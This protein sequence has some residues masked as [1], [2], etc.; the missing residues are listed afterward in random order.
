MVGPGM[1]PRAFS[2]GKE[3]LLMSFRIITSILIILV[4]CTASALAGVHPSYSEKLPVDTV[5]F[6]T[7][8]NYDQ[9]LPTPNDH[10]RHPLGQWPQR[11]HEL[12]SF[13]TEIASR[14]PRVRLEVH[15]ESYEGR[16]LYNVLVSSEDNIARLDEIK[17]GID[18]LADPKQ[19]TGKAQLDS[20]VEYSPAVAWLGYSIHGDELSGVD[21]AAQLIYHLAAG[22]DEATLN[23]LDNVVVIIDPIENPDG[24]ERYMTMLD[25]YGSHVPN[26]DKNALQHQG[27][28]PWG[29]TNHYLF[30]LN[31]DWI[32]LRQTETTGRVR[33]VVDWHPQ[34]VVDAHEMG[35]DATYLFSPPRQ[36]INYNIPENVMK[37]YSAFAKDQAGAF[38]RRGWPYYT[39]EWNDQWYPGYGSAWATFGGA[40]GILYEMAGVDGRF[41]RQRDNYL[42]TF[43]EAVNKQFTSSL[44]NIS[45]A[46]TNRRALLRDYHNTRKQITSRGEKSGLTFVI[47]PGHDEIKMKRF[48]ETLVHL[49]IDVER[50]TKAFVAKSC[51]DVFGES[52]QTKSFPS[53]AYLVRAAQPD[54]AL[55][56]AI[57]EFDP[58]LNLE[59]LEEERRE[60]E[61]FDDT[62]MYETST[63]SLPLAYGLEAYAINSAQ[64]AT[65]S[66]TEVVL[67]EGTLVNP[68]AH[69]GFVVDMV[70]EKTFL[71]MNRLFAEE[72]VFYG[73]KKPFT[74]EGRS[75]GPGALVLRSRGN[76]GNMPVIL[77]RLAE[78][79]GIDIVGVNTGLSSEGSLLGAPT[80]RLMKR[81]KIALFTG[82]GINYG[83]F[84]QLWY[85]ID[86]ELEIP[87]S[88]LDIANFNRMDLSP[89]N[90]LV[91]P[92]SWGPLSSRVDKQGGKK[93]KQWVEGG[94]TLIC[95]NE[96]AAWAADT[97]RGFCSVRLKRQVL[98]K[99]PKYLTGL[100]RERAAESPVV[101]TMAI[102]H[103][104][105]VSAVK[106]EDDDKPAKV[107]KKTAKENDKWQRK[108]FPRGV[109]FLAH[110][111][112]DHWMNIG[113]GDRIPVS[114]YGGYCFMADKPVATFARLAD[115]DQLRLSG[116]LWP[117]ARERWANGVYGAREKIGKGQIIMFA[118]DPNFRAYNYGTRTLF[119]N[120]LLYGPGMGS[121]ANEPYE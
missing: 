81:P 102:W 22:N 33:T 28:Y 26:Y 25:T 107:D 115:T 86:R 7:G 97:A 39:G 96:S 45:T 100:Q 32:L 118:Q 63:W 4:V 62:R 19:V 23:I 114:Y 10:L 74:I 31:R 35:P 42:L 68:D 121:S 112:T 75:F 41:V 93:L 76:P 80:F 117:E 47:V 78:D 101:D 17:R 104:E 44:A 8:G 89:Y 103:P 21:A 37:W 48:V 95:T 83:S 82:N 43:H 110:L 69:Y 79:I 54:G 98:D 27:V 72:L 30:D 9:S 29:R 36:P 67:S 24:R 88:L 34:L 90:V 12:V 58:H 2:H 116:L 71:L 52:S 94:G 77:G 99:L 64:V 108:F 61:K 111:D 73:S 85:C 65:E 13:V 51:V 55:A 70:G 91:L 105:R 120:A 14:S 18:L 57:L 87:H 49:G 38:D 113:M 119:V 3:T 11:Y 5:P 53:G 109:Y 84:G 40:V 20:L 46:A 92:S 106:T 56:K 59:F 15:G 66:V 50:T 6:Y 1:I 16:K 60:I